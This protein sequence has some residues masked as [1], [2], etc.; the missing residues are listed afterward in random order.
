MDDIKEGLQEIAGGNSQAAVLV[1]IVS[2]KGSTP[3]SPGARMIV[4]GDGR[5]YGTIGGGCGE[6]EVRREALNALRYRINKWYTL[7]MTNDTAEEEGMVCGG[8]MDV[9]IEYVDES[10]AEF[11]SKCLQ[12]INQKDTFVLLTLVR[13]DDS[14]Q[15]GKKLLITNSEHQFGDLGC[16]DLNSAAIE[17]YAAIGKENKPRLINL[18]H[19][20]K[21]QEN[22]TGFKYQL[23]YEKVTAPIEL[24]VLGG[25][26]IALPLCEM[27]KILGYHVTVVDDRPYF[28]NTQRFSSVDKVIC[29]DFC[30]ALEEIEVTPATF[31]VI[32]TRGHRHDK[33]CLRQV[34]ERPAGYIGMIGS[35]RRVKALMSELAEEGISVELLNKVYSPIGLKISAE[36]PQE[37]AVSILAE[38]IQVQRG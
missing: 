21:V 6:A 27:G 30:K 35:K 2:V 11:L 23:F 13:S 34:I 9:F 37:I 12:F 10:Q 22:N 31:I 17:L 20:F 8:T 7:D 3:R 28:A 29:N 38:I 15:V 19:E 36:T 33:I 5:T 24:L 32:V 1:T 14:A 18:D 26:H 4:F 16:P 25:G